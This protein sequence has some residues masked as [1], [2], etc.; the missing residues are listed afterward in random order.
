MA[1]V[2]K[3]RHPRLDRTVAIKI[4]PSSLASDAD[5][6]QR[7]EREAKAV[8]ALRHPNIVQMFD[9]G[10]VEGLYYM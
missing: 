10:D 8:A 1:E 6:R 3:G 9:F 4:L 2:Y 5:F 7:F